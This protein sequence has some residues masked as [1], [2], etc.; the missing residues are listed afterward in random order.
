MA[1]RPYTLLSCATSLDGYLD[2]GTEKRLM[3][4][5]DADFDR[6]DEVRAA[7]DAILVGATTVR[8]DNPRLLVRAQ[9]RRDER[10]ARGLQ[11][12]PAKVT[13]TGRAK[14]D[15]GANFFTAGDSEKLVYC[16]SETVDEARDL[17]G[18]AATV[19]DGGQR[20]DMRR[21]SEDLYDRGVHQLMVEGG[22]VVLTQ[23]LTDSLAD[24]LHLVIAPFFVGESLA[25]RFVSDGRFPWHPGRPAKLAEV[26]RID[27][28]VLL[29]YALSD[30]FR[31]G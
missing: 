5:N 3:L 4:S 26:R 6:V 9:A 10:V 24:E 28:V 31:M 17:L 11:P 25:P 14:L 20:V 2:D 13:V 29:R 12:S 18:S 30:R 21:L 16:A 19:V 8:N 1:D 27:D 23:F 15:P 7:S 22:G